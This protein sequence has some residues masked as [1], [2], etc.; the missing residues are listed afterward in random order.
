M[1]MALVTSHMGQNF[2]PSVEYSAVAVVTVIREIKK[3]RR[4]G[5]RG[6]YKWTEGPAL[7]SGKPNPMV[8]AV[9]GKIYALAVHADYSDEPK[10]PEAIDPVFEVLDHQGAWYPL[11]EPPFYSCHST[12]PGSAL[13]CYTAIGNIIYVLVQ[14]PGDYVELLY[15]FNVLKKKWKEHPRGVKCGDRV[16]DSLANHKWS[17]KWADVVD[18][19]LYLSDADLGCC[20]LYAHDCTTSK[21]KVVMNKMTNVLTPRTCGDDIRDAIAYIARRI[22]EGL[23]VYWDVESYPECDCDGVPYLNPPVR[24]LR[25]LVCSND[26]L[27]AHVGNQ[28]F[29]VVC[30]YNLPPKFPGSAGRVVYTCLLKLV[31]SIEQHLQSHLWSRIERLLLKPLKTCQWVLVSCNRLLRLSV[32]STIDDSILNIV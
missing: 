1:Q 24:L 15:S 3:K 17:N 30:A 4:E 21:K 19:K 23:L 29:F 14:K 7:K 18:G 16:G 11:P 22:H 25:M 20:L 5:A 26:S 13:L 6:E 32:I 2:M 31:E 8:V 12:F 10:V 9:K 28:M 27:A